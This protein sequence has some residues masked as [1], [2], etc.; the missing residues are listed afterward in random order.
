MVKQTQND[1][2][3]MLIGSGSD[4]SEYL[5]PAGDVIGFSSYRPMDSS[6][7]FLEDNVSE[8]L[9]VALCQD[10]QVAP[11]AS[12]EVEV[13]VEQLQF[14]FDPSETSIEILKL[15]AASSAGEG[16][17]SPL[18]NMSEW[19]D[20]TEDTEVDELVSPLVKAE[21]KN[22]IRKRRQYEGKDEITELFVEPEPEK[23][24][25]EE[26]MRRIERREKNKLAAQKCRSKKRKVAD[27]LE[28]ETDRLE[29]KQE[30]LKDEVRRLREE[31]DHLTELVNVHSSVCPRMKCPK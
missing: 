10:I 2:L 28:E 31:R 25:E 29:E 12:A 19:S 15:I 7:D 22:R 11:D 27:T 18:D 21:I 8:P 4:L 9:D 17:M 6:M 23:L 3:D 24:T 16:N 14:T 1:I 26:E 13:E 30:K 20:R 5:T